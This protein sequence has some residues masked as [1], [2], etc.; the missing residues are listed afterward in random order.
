[1]CG[2]SD[3]RDCPLAATLHRPPPQTWMNGDAG[4]SRHGD[5]ATQQATTRPMCAGIAMLHCSLKGALGRQ[6]PRHTHHDICAS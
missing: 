6:T 4:W 1:M 2:L 5:V 3:R